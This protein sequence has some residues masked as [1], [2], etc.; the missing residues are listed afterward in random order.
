[1]NHLFIVFETILLALA[2]IVKAI[3]VPGIEG[4]VLASTICMFFKS[5][6]RP[7]ISVSFHFKGLFLIGKPPPEKPVL[8][9]SQ[10]LLRNG[11]KRHLKLFPIFF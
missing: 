8:P 10:T 2:I 6:G 5:L 11:K 3:V 4:K 9:G 1:M 7:N